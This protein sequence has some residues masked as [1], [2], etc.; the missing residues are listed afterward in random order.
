MAHRPTLLKTVF[1]LIF[2]ARNVSWGIQCFQ[3]R[4][5]VILSNGE[6]G[7]ISGGTM[8]LLGW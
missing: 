7:G 2:T 3:R 6:E 5:S 1:H 8:F 4:P